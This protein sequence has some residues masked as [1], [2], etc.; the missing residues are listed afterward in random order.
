MSLSLFTP[1]VAEEWRKP[2]PE[3]KDD[4]ASVVR[5]YHERT[6]HRLDKYARGPETLDWESAP[7]PFRRFEGARVVPLARSRD[8]P[9]LIAIEARTP[10]Q[11]RGRSGPRPLSAATIGVLLE[12]CL[13][14]TAWK[15][16][17]PDRWAVRANPSSGNLH[18]VE[19]YLLTRGVEG[20]ADGVHHYQPDEHVLA[21]R[22][23]WAPGA[24]DSAPRAWIA[25]TTIPWREAWKYGERAF[26]YAEL[27]VGHAIGAVEHAAALFRWTVHEERH[28]GSETLA[29]VLGTGRAEDYP[30]LRFPETEHE[31]PEV[32]LALEPGA[33]EASIEP[34]TLRRWSSA[35]R[36]H[37][38]ATR[39]DPRPM[40]SW[41]IVLDVARATRLPD[42]IPQEIKPPKRRLAASCNGLRTTAAII[43]GRRSARRFDPAFTLDTGAFARLLAPISAN[44]RMRAA[45][46][47]TEPT[48]DLLLFIHR[49][50]SLAPGVYLVPRTVGVPPPLFTELGHRFELRRV[51][52]KARGAGDAFE[53]FELATA[54]PRELM[55]TA[56]LLHCHQEIA[57]TCSFSVAMLADLEVSLA[58]GP[59]TYRRLH[60][61]AGRIGQ[62]LYLRAEAERIG[63]TGI[64]CFFDDAVLEFV[65]LAGTNVRSIY[66]FAIGMPLDDPRI[67]TEPEEHCTGSSRL[68]R[69]K[70]TEPH[71]DA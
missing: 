11:A 10:R 43:R 65:G 33:P 35:A 15:R 6:K 71:D 63:G 14:I 28:V 26:R 49:V 58:A 42:R 45:A 44:S 5:A 8:C 48:L 24:E 40:Y 16:E 56:R 70:S 36:F 51:R 32:L 19:G 37:G 29:Q 57:A 46:S 7:S 55:R 30:A 41:P 4:A 66:H 9:E 23:S 39:I 50:Q 59:S 68:D 2:V 34:L 62:T 53:L 3:T 17:G 21:E 25:L 67:S 64:G 54:P 60:R 22:V 61:Q 38:R 20:L 27:D 52:G 1:I 12:H 18:P 13:G 69:A 31:E 47:E